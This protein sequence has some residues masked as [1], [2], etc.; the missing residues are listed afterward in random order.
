M[1]QKN[2]RRCPTNISLDEL[3]RAVDYNPE[4]GEFIWRGIGRRAGRSALI[5]NTHGYRCGS[6]GGV[7]VLA[8]RAAWAL[9]N[10]EWPTDEVDHI[11]GDR[12]DNRMCNLRLVSMRENH[13]NQRLRGTNT[14]GVNG[15]YRIKETGRW[16][17]RI[18][19][20]GKYI[21]LGVFQCK[22]AAAIIR[23]LANTKYGFHPLHG[24]IK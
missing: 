17:A 2:K 18:R 13:L 19:V 22:S 4:T 7:R 3:R 16:R 24:E 8:H 23:K 11:N 20:H 21:S 5:T 1:A 10:G 14:S 6:V 12:A 9:E 15:V